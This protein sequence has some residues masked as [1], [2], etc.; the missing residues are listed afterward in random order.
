[1]PINPW[2]IRA[3]VAVS[4]ASL[5]YLFVFKTPSA[6]FK[7]T[8]NQRVHSQIPDNCLFQNLHDWCG[9]RVS[10]ATSD[11]AAQLRAAVE[12]ATDPKQVWCGPEDDVRRNAPSKTYRFPD[13]IRWYRLHHKTDPNQWV[14]IGVF[15]H[16]DTMR[17]TYWIRCR[18]HV[19]FEP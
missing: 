13:G 7:E 19:G 8:D 9:L 15:E 5:L 11:E 14:G 4:L 10:V 1:M 16:Y 2:L 17:M 12:D 3:L 6:S 18:V